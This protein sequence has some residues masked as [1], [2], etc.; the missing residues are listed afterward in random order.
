MLFLRTTPFH[1]L[2]CSIH[3]FGDSAPP[4]VKKCF[5]I[6]AVEPASTETY[7]MEGE[8]DGSVPIAPRVPPA[9]FW[10]GLNRQGIDFMEFLY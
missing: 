9:F 4:E 3:Y 5:K 10:P 2:S 6:N 8:W 7:K 1:E